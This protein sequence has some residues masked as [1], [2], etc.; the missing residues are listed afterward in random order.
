M[1]ELPPYFISE[2]SV[3]IYDIN[4]N[5]ERFTQKV[6]SDL[7]IQ[8]NQESLKNAARALNNESNY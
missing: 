7:L 8:L 4:T 3:R 6:M 1:K 2:L 5:L